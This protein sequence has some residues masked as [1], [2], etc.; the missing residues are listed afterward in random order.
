MTAFE[1]AKATRDKLAADVARTSAVLQTFPTE[2]PMNLTPDA[3]KFSPMF[4]AAKAQFDAAFQR[5]RAFNTVFVKQF[6]KEIREERRA[7]Q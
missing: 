3:V 4:R 7:R 5:L 2:G 6:A 1:I